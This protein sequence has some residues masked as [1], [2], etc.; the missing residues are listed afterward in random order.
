MERYIVCCY[1]AEEAGHF[2]AHRDNTT[3]GTAHRRFAVTVNLNHDFDGGEISFPEFGPRSYKPPVGA[4]LVFSCSMLHQVS[5]VTRGER[6]AF[7]PFLYDEAA[8]KLREANTA[9][10]DESLANYRAAPAAE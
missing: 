6:F 2:R 9:H 10:V 4:A 3:A 8:A 7:L 1:S 5:P